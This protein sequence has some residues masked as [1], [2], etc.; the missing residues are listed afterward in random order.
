M[1]FKLTEDCRFLELINASELE[2]EQL[3]ITLTKKVNNWRFNPRVQ[4]GYWDGNYCYLYKNK[5]VPSGL[6]KVVVD[7][8]KKYDFPIKLEDIRNLFD[9]EIDLDDFTEWAMDFFDGFKV[10]GEEVR[11]RDYQIETAFRILKFKKCAAELATSAGKTL[12]SFMVV[13]YMLEKGLVNRILFIVPNVSLVVQAYNDF[14]EYNFRNKVKLKMQMIYSGQEEINESNIVIGTYQSLVK[15]DK[16]Y[17][18]EFD[19]V[20]VDETHKAKAHS[21]KEI[22]E[23][24][25]NAVYRYGLTGTFPK[26]DT[27]DR[28]SLMCYTGPL[29]NE[30]NASFL[31]SQGTITKCQVKIIQMDYANESTKRS[32]YELSKNPFDR[33]NLFNLEQNYIIENKT[34]LTMVSNI[35]KASTKSSLVL[36]FHR[37]YGQALYDRLRESTQGK[38]IYY[39]DGKTDSDIREIYKKKMENNDNV[40]LIASYG[41]FSTGISVNNIHNIFF[42]ESFKSEVI[43]RQSI[44][45]G[46]RKH[47]SKELLTIV[48]FVDDFNYEGWKCYHMKH[49]IVRQEIYLDQKFPY[50]IKKLKF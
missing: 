23:K 11:P 25:E 16:S 36:F 13:A 26:P 5:Y 2:L 18:N 50:E 15:K 34:R 37:D 20:A 49:G 43:I 29:V 3:R 22:L 42:T 33:K 45:R 31:Q 40:I 41:T 6:W 35:I 39:V 17:F 7:M 30:V 9:D 10:K 38:L 8:C 19:A 48:D 14:I 46:L 21:I 27:L 1:E 4:N 12:I 44:G 47:K 32:F 28:L 24:C